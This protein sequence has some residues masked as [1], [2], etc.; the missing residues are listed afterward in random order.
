MPKNVL[1]IKVTVSSISRKSEK[2][3]ILLKA[4]HELSG[5]TSYM[6]RNTASYLKYGFRH[7]LY[8][9]SYANLS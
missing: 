6:S 9:L 5:Q 2:G 8:S 3:R 4:L 1:V 7:P